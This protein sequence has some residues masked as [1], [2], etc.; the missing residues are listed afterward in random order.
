MVYALMKE[1]GPWNH[2]LHFISFS[3]SCI[4][5]WLIHVLDSP[6]FSLWE[7]QWKGLSQRLWPP[8]RGHD[9]DSYSQW[10]SSPNTFFKQRGVPWNK[11]TSLTTLSPCHSATLSV[12]PSQELMPVPSERVHCLC[13]M[14]PLLWGWPF[15]SGSK[16]LDGWLLVN[17]PAIVCVC[18]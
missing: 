5:W 9:D 16:I 18:A 6:N 7:P 11:R 14:E 10:A 2:P 4:R 12:E 13:Q 15:P 3:L 1:R 17:I 8:T